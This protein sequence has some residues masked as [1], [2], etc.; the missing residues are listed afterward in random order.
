MWSEIFTFIFNWIVGPILIVILFIWDLLKKLV[1][2]VS[3]SVYKRIV[4]ILAILIV[5]FILSK[6]FK[7]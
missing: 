2:D 3:K 1:S 4:T 6:L 5:G 7:I